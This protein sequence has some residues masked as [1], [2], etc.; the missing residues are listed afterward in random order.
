MTG[1]MCSGRWVIYHERTTE[2]HNPQPARV[3]LAELRGFIEVLLGDL[4]SN[5]AIGRRCDAEQR[6]QRQSV[7]MVPNLHRRL[8][9]RSFQTRRTRPRIFSI[10]SLQ[11]IGTLFSRLFQLPIPL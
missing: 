5:L 9:L 11:E 4:G 8:P 2:G 6:E 7:E 3:P 1:G 10:V